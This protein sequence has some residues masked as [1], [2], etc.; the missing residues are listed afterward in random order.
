MVEHL[1]YKQYDGGPIPPTSTKGDIKMEETPK[2][3]IRSLFDELDEQEK[4]NRRRIPFY[5]WLNDKF[6]KGYAGYSTYYIVTHPWEIL[7][8]WKRE[9]KYAWQRAF[10]GWD[11]NAVWGIDIYLSVLI[12]K[13]VR[14]LK[15]LE[16]KGL[17]QAVFE[18]LPYE[19][20]KTYSYSEENEKI[21]SERWNN[22][23][24]EIAQGFEAYNE[25][26]NLDDEAIK[27]F[28]RAFDLFRLHFGSLGD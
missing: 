18:G 23:L 13:L 25:A 19:N 24:E 22:I 12:P 6:P 21:A 15:T 10:R 4:E 3:T 16:L 9:I 26:S 7:R 8:F 11:D 1:S 28:E 14:E 5:A 27:K 17:P 20:E 2:K